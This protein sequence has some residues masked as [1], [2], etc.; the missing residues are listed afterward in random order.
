MTQGKCGIGVLVF[1]LNAVTRLLEFS[2][3]IVDLLPGGQVLF[4]LALDH[5]ALV[6]GNGLGSLGLE[7]LLGSL[8]PLLGHGSGPDG[9]GKHACEGKDGKGTGDYSRGQE[10]DVAALIWGRGSAGSMGTKGD[11]VS[12]LFLLHGQFLPVGL[13]AIPQSHPQVGL[14]LGRHVFPALL[15][16]GQGRVG[17]GMRLA[18]VLQLAGDGGGSGQSG[19]ARGSRRHDGGRRAPLSADER[20]AQHGCGW[21]GDGRR[22]LRKGGSFPSRDLQLPMGGGGGGGGDGD[23]MCVVGDWLLT[24]PLLAL[25]NL[26]ARSNHQLDAI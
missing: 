14:L 11:E 1:V 8:L 12:S 16:V 9:A 25:Q 4:R 23:G 2:L 15:D 26:G 20:R 18:D 17:D 19:G 3:L 21:S 24:N 10:E 5:H 13:H 6:A 7:V 22:V